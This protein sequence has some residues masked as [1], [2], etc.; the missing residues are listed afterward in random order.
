MQRFGAEKGSDSQPPRMDII[1]E[2]PHESR[3]WRGLRMRVPSDLTAQ[4]KGPRTRAP[5]IR[6][7]HYHE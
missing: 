2:P 4:S 3:P 7:P 5:L 1:V 6:G